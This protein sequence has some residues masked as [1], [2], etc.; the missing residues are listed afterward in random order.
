MVLLVS[1]SLLAPSS[2]DAAH[3]KAEPS[4]KGVPCAAFNPNGSWAATRNALLTIGSLHV[5]ADAN[6]TYLP[7][8]INFNGIDFAS[9]LDT[10]CAAGGNS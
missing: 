6:T 7:N 3:K 9:Y 8:T 5:T 4:S 2:A 1:A 10:H